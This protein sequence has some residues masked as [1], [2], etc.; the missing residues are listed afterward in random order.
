MLTLCLDSSLREARLGP[1]PPQGR[2]YDELKELGFRAAENGALREAL[3]HYQESLE[4]AREAEDQILVDLAVCNCSALEITLGRQNEVKADLREIL[5]SGRCPENSF[6]AAYQLSRAH[7]R[8]KAYKKGL[9]YA[10]V[11]RDRA[12]SMGR[13]DWL[14]W[15][16]NQLAN[17]LMDE[18]RFAEAAKEYRRALRLQPEDKSVFRA[19]LLVNLGYCLMM[20]G[21]MKDGLPLTFRSLRW[22]RSFGARIYEVWAHLDLCYAYIELDRIRRAQDHGRRALALAEESGDGDLRKIA[23]YLL[24]ETERTADNLE[25]AYKYFSCLQS[26]YYPESPQLVETVM[27]VGTRQLVNLRA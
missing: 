16:Y 5:M 14:V 12:T 4:A 20:R 24:G 7:V 9:F 10:Q 8:D 11:A 3:G 26:E 1:T 13:D 21:R 25:G 18:S 2:S 19:V 27:L 17:C 15:S 23:L 6:L 22:F